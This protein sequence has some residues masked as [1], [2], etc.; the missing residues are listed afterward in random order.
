[1]GQLSRPTLKIRPWRE[2]RNEELRPLTI[3]KQYSDMEAKTSLCGY[4]VSISHCLKKP[5]W[6]E[7]IVKW[8]VELEKLK[9]PFFWR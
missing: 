9:E 2:Q 5:P 1:M 4:L 7:V 3:G 6:L 8:P